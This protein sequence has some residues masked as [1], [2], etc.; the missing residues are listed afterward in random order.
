MEKTIPGIHHITAIASDPQRNLDFYAGTLGLRLVKLTVNFD[1]PSTYHFY[2]ADELGHPGTILTFFPWPGGLRGRVGTGQLTTIRFAVPQGALGYW[3]DRLQR[4][5]VSSERPQQRFD[6][7]ALAFTDP[8]GLRLELEEQPEAE[9]RSGWAGGPVPAEYALRGFSGVTLTEMDH[10]ETAALLTETL[11]FCP[12]QQEGNRFRYQVGTGADRA[13]IDIVEA[14]EAPRGLIAAGNVHHIAWRTPT[15]E[16]QLAWRAQLV[17]Q[18]FHVTQVRDRQYFHS[19]YF[20][21]PG[22]VLFEIATD[23]PGFAIDEPPEQLGTH[24][25]LPPWLEPERAQLERK[26]P[27][28]RLPAAPVGQ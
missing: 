4:A 12:A 21:E 24:L 23:P 1:D 14:P 2:F 11:G 7:Q 25:K 27:P 6:A 9:L 3:A 5:G 20:H 28:L 17:D 18:G 26:L 10:A 19:I 16:A 8:D 13:F 22:G 15:D